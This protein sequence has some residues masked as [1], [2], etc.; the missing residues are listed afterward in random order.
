MKRYVSQ[1]ISAWIVLG[2]TFFPEP[3]LAIQAHGGNEGIVVH[4][5]GHLFFFVSMGAFAYW[6]RGGQVLGR[7]GWRYIMGFALLMGLWNVDVLLMHFL[8]EQSHLVSVAKTGPWSVTING[9]GSSFLPL[10]Y[11]LGKL[12]HLICVPA[13]FLLYLGLRRIKASLDTQTKDKVKP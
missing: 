11:Y 2:W 4:Q 8:D 5:M 7:A 12:D 13:L 10:I 1:Y 9:G 3:L 6:L